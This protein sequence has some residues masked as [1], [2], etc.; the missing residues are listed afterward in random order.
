MNEEELFELPFKCGETSPSIALGV[1]S[2]IRR[3]WLF[4]SGNVDIECL[5]Q[6]GPEKSVV[7]AQTK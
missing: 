5:R 1:T 4:D 3:V 6:E 2:M 7:E